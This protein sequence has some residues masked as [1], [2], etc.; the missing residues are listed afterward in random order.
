MLR[1]LDTPIDNGLME[2]NRQEEQQ[3]KPAGENHRWQEMQEQ[4]RKDGGR[5]SMFRRAWDA[6]VGSLGTP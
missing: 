4:F 1:M 5:R 3:T 2:S 6:L